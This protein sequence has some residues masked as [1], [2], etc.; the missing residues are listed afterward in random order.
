MIYIAELHYLQ[1]QADFPVHKAVLVTATAVSRWSSRYSAKLIAARSNHISPSTKSGPLPA[2][3]KER[4]AL[5]A[6]LVSWL[7]E[8]SLVDGLFY[9]I[10]D[11]EPVKTLDH[12]AKFDHHDDTG[13][14]ALDLE[15]DEFAELQGEWKKHGLPGDLF[16]PQDSVFCIP[17]PGGGLRARLLRAVG[18][19]KCYTPKQW[20]NKIDRNAGQAAATSPDSS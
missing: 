17:Y 8:S 16:C 14:W 12:V 3:L 11:N 4:E 18:V 2:E 1:D 10:L 13:S 9:L 19:K 5:V 15:E 7:F 20:E 6:E